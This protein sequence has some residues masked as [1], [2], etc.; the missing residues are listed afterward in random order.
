M[1]LKRG[2]R[3]EKKTKKQRDPPFSNSWFEF[4]LV[5]F[6]SYGL[7]QKYFSVHLPVTA[8]LSRY[9]RFFFAYNRKFQHFSRS[10]FFSNA[11]ASKVSPSHSLLVG[12]NSLFLPRFSSRTQVLTIFS[13][14]SFTKLKP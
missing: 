9:S 8:Q 10:M 4:F 2:R 5:F 7:V 12:Y 1:Y 11:E 13:P 6:V 14:P 3:K